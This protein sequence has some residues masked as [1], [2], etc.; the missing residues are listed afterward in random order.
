MTTL[1]SREIRVP[2]SAARWSWIVSVNLAQISKRGWRGCRIID[3]FACFTFASVAAVLFTIA[4]TQPLQPLSHMTASYEGY[5]QHILL[6]ED[7]RVG[8][9]FQFFFDSLCSNKISLAFHSR[10]ETKKSAGAVH[11]YRMGLFFCES[12]RWHSYWCTLSKTRVKWHTSRWHN[13]IL[14]WL[15]TQHPDFN[16]PTKYV[17]WKRKRWE[18]T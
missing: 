16:N 8:S 10:A 14:Y 2:L 7:L 15:R 13:N 6:L 1:S 4:W 18:R 11:Q 5:G 9:A 3:L 17:T 12:F